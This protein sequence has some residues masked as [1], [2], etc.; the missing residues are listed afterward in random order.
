MFVDLEN[1]TSFSV[2]LRAKI[3]AFL[4]YFYQRSFFFRCQFLFTIKVEAA[5][6]RDRPYENLQPIFAVFGIRRCDTSKGLPWRQGRGSKVSD[7]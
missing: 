7:G 5:E 6:L 4:C 3:D 2:G 1:E